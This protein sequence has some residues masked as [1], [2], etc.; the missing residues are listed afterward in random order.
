MD[1]IYEVIVR[2][3]GPFMF[4]TAIGITFL[5][6]DLAGSGI[7]ETKSAWQ[8][9]DAMTQKASSVS[10]DGVTQVSGYDLQNALANGS[11]VPVVV[12]IPSELRQLTITFDQ[13]GTK[14]SANQYSTD[15]S[16]HGIVAQ[17][18]DLAYGFSVIPDDSNFEVTY[19]YDATNK[20]VSVVY[21]EEE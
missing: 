19:K 8:N 11:D 5:L 2:L 9:S 20:L 3:I 10:A 16:I 12:T 1:A 6:A 7:N 13:L 18:K 15:G 17:N 14:V 4:A 21:T